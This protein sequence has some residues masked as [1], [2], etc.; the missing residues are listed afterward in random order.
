MSS[1]D[2]EADEADFSTVIE[3]VDFDSIENIHF[4]EVIIFINRLIFD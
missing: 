4:G 2:E 1:S 3:E